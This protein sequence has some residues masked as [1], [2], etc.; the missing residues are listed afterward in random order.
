M[1]LETD[2]NNQIMKNYIV[3]FVTLKKERQVSIPQTLCEL[4]CEDSN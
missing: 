1:T 3:S 4:F 2:K